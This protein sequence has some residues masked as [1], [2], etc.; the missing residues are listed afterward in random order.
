MALARQTMADWMIAAAAACE[1]VLEALQRM[2]RSGPAMFID[3]TSVQMMKEPGRANTQKSYAWAACGGDPRRPVTVFR[4]EPT[5]S[6]DVAVE[7]VGEFCGYVR[8]D[9][10]R[11]YGSAFEKLKGVIHVG[12]LAHA[13]RKFTDAANDGKKTSST[14]EALALIG[15]IYAVGRELKARVRDEA[16]RTER[17]RRVRPLL[18]KLAQ[19]PPKTALGKAVTYTLEQLPKIE[20]YL[21]CE[22]LTPDTNRVENVI[23]PFVVGR[24]AWLFS[25]SLRGANA[26]MTLYSLIETAKANKVE[27]Y[28]YLRRPFDRLPTFDTDDDYEDLLPWRIFSKEA[29]DP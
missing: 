26:S 13:R 2:L 20:R 28:R 27:P 10:Y 12:C 7:I 18:E 29:E 5:R 19:V 15:K 11:A 3:E 24:K 1:P 22:H 17:E 25:G 14:R 21:A 23:R 8:T 6:G 16:F 4:Y 9:A